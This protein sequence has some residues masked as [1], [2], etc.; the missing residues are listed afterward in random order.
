MRP[1]SLILLLLA[2]GCGLVAAV[3]INRVLA[4]RPVEQ[5]PDNGEMVPIFVALADIGLGD[6]LTAEVLK[7]EEWPKTKVPPGAMTKLEE[8][9]GRRARTK[10][11]GGEPIIEAKL[12]ARGDQGSGATDLIPKGYRVVAVKVDDVSGSGLILPG[13]R[14][15]ALVHLTEIGV[16]GESNR[17]STKTFLHNVK[18]FAVNNVYSRESNGDTAITAKTISLLVTPQQAELVTLANEMGK[19]RLVMRS[20]DD[21]TED[22]TGGVTQDELFQGRAESGHKQHAGASRR[23]GAA[24][25]FLKMLEPPKKPIAETPVARNTWKMLLIE[26]NAMREVEFEDDGKMGAPLHVKQLVGPEDAAPSSTTSPSLPLA[27]ITLPVVPPGTGDPG[28]TNDEPGS[29][30]G[31]G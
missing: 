7:L 25:S 22:E 10:F 30:D 20:A 17:S 19:I 2:L 12:F 14:V 1:K 9:E 5:A 23:K 27:P 8:V 26:G 21:E 18:V 31:P 15:D 11:F 13:D 24:E 4:S 6:P 16:A 3:G 28:T 29:D